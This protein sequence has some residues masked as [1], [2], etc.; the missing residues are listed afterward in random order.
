MFLL[1][2][3]ISFPPL[4]LYV[5]VSKFPPRPCLFRTLWLCFALHESRCPSWSR[6]PCLR[7]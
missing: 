4:A 5:S 6:D 7:V 1:L 2:I 3:N